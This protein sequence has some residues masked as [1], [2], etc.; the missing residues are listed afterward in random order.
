MGS[1]SMGISGSHV[2]V[3]GLLG[4][5]MN[6]RGSGRGSHSNRSRDI[7]IISINPFERRATI[8]VASRRVRTVMTAMAV[9]ASRSNSNGRMRSGRGMRVFRGN[10]SFSFATAFGVETLMR[11]SNGMGGGVGLTDGTV[12]ETR[13]DESGGVCGV[14]GRMVGAV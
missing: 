2:N 8:T 12:V 10:R 4:P 3:G 11:G 13:G 9:G 14:G 1:Y 6:L 5:G 7:I